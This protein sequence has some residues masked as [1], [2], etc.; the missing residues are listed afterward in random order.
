M[1]EQSTRHSRRSNTRSTCTTARSNRTSTTPI[2][3]HGMQ[4]SGR[5]ENQQDN[6]AVESPS[7]VL[8]VSG[9]SEG[10]IINSSLN[11]R[12]FTPLVPAV[13]PTL[14]TTLTPPASR[15]LKPLLR[16]QVDN[17]N[18]SG[19]SV[20]EQ[21]QAF[22]DRQGGFNKRLEEGLEEHLQDQ[23]RENMSTKFSKKFVW[24]NIPK[25]PKFVSN[26]HQTHKSVSSCN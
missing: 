22:F 2:V 6:M 14:R 10:S 4:A 19:S 12:E 5:L 13:V 17:A 20:M 9:S 25:R 7:R 3:S 11:S 24:N 16:T 8:N 26:S 21:L 15:I 23:G 18:D 1:T